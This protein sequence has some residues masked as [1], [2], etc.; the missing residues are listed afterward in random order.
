VIFMVAG[1]L[2][3]SMRSVLLV[4]AVLAGLVAV[5]RGAT[6]ALDRSMAPEARLASSTGPAAT[7]RP[8][9]G[10]HAAVWRPG[11]R[12]AVLLQ[13]DVDEAVDVVPSTLAANQRS[14]PP[15]RH[16]RFITIP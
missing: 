14:A 1:R 2:A 9:T 11:E 4:A 8:R 12:S 5:R 3:V 16:H 15:R 7:S 13:L 10:R 6:G